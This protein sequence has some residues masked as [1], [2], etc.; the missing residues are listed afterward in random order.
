MLKKFSNS[1]FLKNVSSQMLGT[2]LAQMLPFLAT[3]L[4][5]RV[6][7]EEDFA[8]YTSFFAVATIFGVAAGGKYHLATVLPKL[9]KDAHK[10][11]TLSLYITIA[12]AIL[13][14][15][16]LPLFKG[17]FPDNLKHVLYYVSPY[18]LFFGVWS[19]LCLLVWS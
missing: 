8:V 19:A 6:F 17:F 13:I 4:L 10:I 5:T 9:E 7:T 18:V 12:Y 2:G 1:E 16:F 15:I 14:A 3:P 11:F